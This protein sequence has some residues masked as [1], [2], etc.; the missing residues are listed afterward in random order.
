M[1][2]TLVFEEGEIYLLL[3]LEHIDIHVPKVSR[4]FVPS[5]LPLCQTNYELFKLFRVISKTLNDYYRLLDLSVLF[6]KKTENIM[7]RN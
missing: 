5:Q 6:A 2:V 7:L 3:L 1:S 4:H